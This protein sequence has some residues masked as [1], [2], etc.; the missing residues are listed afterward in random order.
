MFASIGMDH[1]DYSM[2]EP[3]LVI[4]VIKKSDHERAGDVQ[5]IKCMQKRENMFDAKV[6]FGQKL[7]MV[8]K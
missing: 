1:V 8:M 3:D 2:M 5:Q 7:S 4:V 6:V